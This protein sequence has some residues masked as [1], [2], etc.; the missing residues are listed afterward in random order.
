MYYY[1]H[2]NGTVI[3]KPDFVVDSAGGP[4]IYFEGPFVERWWWKEDK[5]DVVRP[6]SKEL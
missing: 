5:P 3:Q 2:I 4:E 6:D 1:R